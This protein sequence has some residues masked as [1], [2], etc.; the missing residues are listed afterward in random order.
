MRLQIYE[1]HLRSD[2][3]KTKSVDTSSLCEYNFFK[4]EPKLNHPAKMEWPMRSW[5]MELMLAGL[6]RRIRATSE[7]KPE[8]I[9]CKRKPTF[10]SE[11][12]LMI[13]YR[14]LVYPHLP[15]LQM[16]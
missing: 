2:N 10:T 12:Y 8:Y 6:D 11:Q 13:T 15:D 7:G 9:L 14:I 3:I 1:G 4:V 5:M 16:N